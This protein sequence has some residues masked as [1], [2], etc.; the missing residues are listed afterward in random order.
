MTWQALNQGMN[1]IL[2]STF[3]TVT[4]WNRGAASDSITVMVLDRPGGFDDTP[5]NESIL[6]QI[7][8]LDFSGKIL[9]PG[10]VAGDRVTLSG[11]VYELYLI[12]NP[13]D[14]ATGIG[15]CYLR[16]IS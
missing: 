7:Q 11:A 14:S 12:A 9:D 15:N 13:S 8:Y 5:V 6:V 10:P 4:Q 16:R 2:F 3:P 1:A